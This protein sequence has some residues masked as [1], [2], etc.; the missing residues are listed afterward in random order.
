[1]NDLLNSER[2]ILVSMYSIRKVTDDTVWI[3]GDDRKETI[4]EGMF[5]IPNGVSYNSYVIDDN[6]TIL[7]D[8]CDAS[9][10]HQFWENLMFVLNGRKL[11]YFFVGHME[12]D[13]GACI[14][15]VI[16]VYPD[17]KVISSSRAFDMMNN[18]YG[19]NPKNKI[20][21]KEGDSI[22]IGKHKLVFISAVMV[23]WPEVM[24]A[25]DTYNGTLFCEDAFGTFGTL[26]GSLFA[27]ESNFEEKYLDEARRYYSNIV[28]KYGSNV[29]SVLKK[30]ADVEIKCLCP[31]HG[32]IWRKDL[33]YIIEKYDLWSK[34]IPE[35]KGVV[36]AYSSMYGNT[37]AVANR[38]ATLLKEKGLENLSVINVT[39]THPSYVVSD[40]FKYSNIVLAA[41]TYNNGLHPTMVATIDDMRNM[42]V[43][44]R[45]F[46]L[47]GNGSWAPVSQKIMSEMMAEMKDMEL[48]GEP[49]VIKSAMND[50]QIQ[51]LDKLADA[52]I[53]SL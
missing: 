20:E 17:V 13:H 10:E 43:Q 27:D 50:E 9:V 5:P 30:A 37:E 31:L 6:E 42:A 38:L 53:D 32:P 1:M 25:L 45:K 26:S 14:R 2:T 48:V 23:H 22:T 33:G 19:L 35:E 36:I 12:P 51:E 47:I 4:F 16:D 34:Y 41:P 29:Q 46:S 28:G 8:T 3:G 40:V 24:F 52:I 15:R 21:I 18:F 7:M 44:N 11:D 49:F 39:R